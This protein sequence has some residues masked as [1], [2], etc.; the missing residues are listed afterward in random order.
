MLS[1]KHSNDD[2]DV[3]SDFV[4]VS[5][6]D[7]LSSIRKFTA[8]KYLLTYGA[9]L[10]SFMPQAVCYLDN[11]SRVRAAAGFQSASDAV[12]LFLEQ[13]FD[14]PIEEILAEQLQIQIPDRSHIVELGNFAAN[15]PG[16][17]RQFI[18]RLGKY[19]LNNDFHWLVITATKSIKASFEKMGVRDSMSIICDADMNRLT[20]KSTTWGT[21]YN[22]EP[23]VIAIDIQKG[24]KELMKNEVVRHLIDGIN[25]PVRDVIDATHILCEDYYE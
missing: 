11:Q 5:S 23:K 8:R 17:T 21:Y 22:H 25:D 10:Q 19:L 16:A 18:L 7:N 20:D 14:R 4:I 6:P 24:L 13:Y 2:Y 12:P 1:N 15:T 3:V 9:H